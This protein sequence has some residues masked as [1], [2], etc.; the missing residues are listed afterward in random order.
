MFT[1]TASFTVALALA[2]A[3]LLSPTAEGWRP[4]SSVQ[5]SQRRIPPASASCLHR[6]RSGSPSSCSTPRSF[7]PVM[8][9]AS[10]SGSTRLFARTG[11][12]GRQQQQDQQRDDAA[13]AAGGDEQDQKKQKQQKQD[14]EQQTERTTFDEAGR[15]LVAEEDQARMEEM[16]DFDENPSVRVLVGA[17]HALLVE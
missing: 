15:S 5:R 16:G 13:A 3:A 6:I 10:T 7:L 17:Y 11:K 9:T 4:S 8:P 1:G 14:Q 2:L 12:K